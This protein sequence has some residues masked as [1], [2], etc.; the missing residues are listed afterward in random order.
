M[1]LKSRNTAAWG[2][3]AYGLHAC[4]ILWGGKNTP[5][6]HN[7]AF[8]Y[9]FDVLLAVITTISFYFQSVLLCVCVSARVYMHATWEEGCQLY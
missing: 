1:S 2:Q 9:I 6:S 3:T 7:T 4:R 5:F 8:S